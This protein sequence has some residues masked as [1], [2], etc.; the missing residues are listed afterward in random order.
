M[1]AEASACVECGAKIGEPS[2]DAASIPSRAAET[3]TGRN[4]LSFQEDKNNRRF[5][6]SLT[7]VAMQ[8]LGSVFGDLFAQRG[9]VRL[10]PQVVNP[11]R[12]QT[13]IE[14]PPL[15]IPA[16]VTL[17]ESPEA[18]F[19][20]Q[21]SVVTERNTDKESVSAFFSSNGDKLELIDN[22]L[23]ASSGAEYLRQLTYLYL[24]AHEL[25]GRTSVP[26]RDLNIM[27]TAAKMM[28]S[29]GNTRRWLR[30]RVGISEEGEGNI[31][32]NNVGRDGAKKALK[33]ALD[34]N[35]ATAW[36]PDSAAS[37]PKAAKGSKAKGKAKA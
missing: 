15:A 32:L 22:R 33:D 25:H 2:T 18:S 13:Q 17:P 19:V 34:T 16:A 4:T 27:L 37:K 35:I 12:P 31:K 24:Y 3:L 23:K 9:V 6:A 11:V 28:D 5:E 14:V 8:S 26:E 10:P 21:Q 7:D 1:E 29:S 30:A 36:N 20:T